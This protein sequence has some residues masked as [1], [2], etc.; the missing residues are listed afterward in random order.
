MQPLLD[1][2]GARRHRGA[3]WVTH[4]GPRVRTW[5]VFFL[6]GT[7]SWT[8]VTALFAEAAYF[9]KVLPEGQAIY[10]DLDCAME[11]GNIVPAILFL[12]VSSE[13]QLRKHNARITGAA[14]VVAVGAAIL[15]ATTWN[16]T[17]N[18]GGTAAHGTSLFALLAAWL[19][20][21]IGSTSMLTFF[22]FAAP[23]GRDAISA[24]SVGIG[25]CGLVTNILGITQGLPWLKDHHHGGKNNLT[26]IS[27]SNDG[28]GESIVGSSEL[29]F[30]AS[31]APAADDGLTFGPSVFFLLVG[32]W[33]VL[34]AGSFLTIRWQCCGLSVVVVAD[35][36]TDRV[37]ETNGGVGYGRLLNDVEGWRRVGAAAN[38]AT[39]NAHGDTDNHSIDRSLNFVNSALSALGE[40]PGPMAGIFVSCLTQF[41][42]PGLVPYLVPCGRD[43]TSSSFWVT[44]FY[45][46][47][48]LLGRM[49]TVAVQCRRFTLLNLLQTSG[50]V[51]AII[52][53]R[54]A[55]PLPLWL[56]IIVITVFSAVH[57][58]I[59][60][61]VFHIVGKSAQKSAVGGLMNQA[62]ALTG[63]LC[64]FL[65]VKMDIIVK[66]EC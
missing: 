54:M 7:L 18:L 8:L 45:L 30:H 48:S 46:T 22:N 5:A 1:E 43:H 28:Q 40:N 29:H 35:D 49:V 50:L 2:R 51:Y 25:A 23:Y 60:T 27:S 65:L 61:E 13:R 59:V 19:S 58:Y 33:L 52:V 53:T 16:I 3:S 63:S 21:A 56:S 12:Y 6:F 20:G 42:M 57:G 15:W 14:A 9:Q 41:A 36:D 38:S 31:P 17:V 10:A 26:S 4:V 47:G 64:T 62:G 24:T 37:G 44:M 11:L 55:V 66:R 34:A 32:A 39:V